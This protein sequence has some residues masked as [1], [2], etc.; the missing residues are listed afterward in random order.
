MSE[1]SAPKLYSPT[2][3]ALSVSLADYPLD[4]TFDA[5]GEALSRTC[6]SSIKLGLK[7]DAGRFSKVGMQVSACAVG[8][9]SAALLA[10]GLE[11]ASKDDVLRTHD[12][13]ALWLNGSGILPEWPG[14]AALAPALPYPGRHDAILLPWRAAIEALSSI[15]PNG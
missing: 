13:I 4:D 2:L 9:S 1:G 3:L 6:G 7:M 10:Q 8:Q 15:P 14:F 5:Y 11:S 12:E